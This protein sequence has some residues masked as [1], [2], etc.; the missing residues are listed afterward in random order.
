MKKPR[1]MSHKARERKYQIGY[2]FPQ[3][4]SLMLFAFFFPHGSWLMASASSNKK[5]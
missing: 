2:F 5:L 4:S 3:H 1:A